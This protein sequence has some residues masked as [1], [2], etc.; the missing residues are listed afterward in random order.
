[1]NRSTRSHF[2]P[3]TRARG[4]K[5]ARKKIIS[6]LLFLSMIAGLLVFIVSHSQKTYAAATN[7]VYPAPVTE[8][9]IPTVNAAP[10]S[11]AAGPDGNLWFTEF[12]Y[13]KTGATAGK[14]GR[15]TTAGNISYFPL[16]TSSNI[17]TSITFGKDHTL[18]FIE[19]EVTATD[20]YGK[21]GKIGHL[22]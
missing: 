5:R 11:I 13:D 12:Q 8:F 18:W 1:M 2:L 21:N 4:K 20:P 15:I 14:I 7:E 17:P 19:V 22:V 10:L 9:P 6:M 3:L 16:P